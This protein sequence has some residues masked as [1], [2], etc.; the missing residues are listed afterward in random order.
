[1]RKRPEKRLTSACKTDIIDVINKGDEEAGAETAVFKETA[2]LGLKGAE[3]VFGTALSLWS[4]VGEP[5]LLLC[6]RRA[7]GRR[8]K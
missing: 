1:M 3:N 2:A 6:G 8:D 7:D 5:L 4:F